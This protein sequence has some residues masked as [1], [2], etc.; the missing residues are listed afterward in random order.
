MTVVPTPESPETTSQ[1]VSSSGIHLTVNAVARGNP[2]GVLPVAI[3][4]PLILVAVTILM[5]RWWNR[6]RTPT[7]KSAS[8]DGP[9]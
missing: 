5:R 1:P 6:E 3:G 4:V 8:S 2:G 9:R 7:R